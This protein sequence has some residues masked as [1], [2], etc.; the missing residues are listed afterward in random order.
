MKNNYEQGF[1]VLA[2][3][4]NNFLLQDKIP[5]LVAIAGGTCSGKT[6]LAGILSNYLPQGTAVVV[7]IDD[8]FKNFDDSSLPRNFRKIPN[9]D[10]PEAYRTQRLISTITDLKNGKVSF[11]PL[12][13]MKTNTLVLEEGIKLYPRQVIIA[14]GL[15]AINFL[16]GFDNQI[17]VFLD[18]NP[19]D[20]FTRRVSRDMAKYKV[21]YNQ[22]RN[23]FDEVIWPSHLNFVAGQKDLADIVIN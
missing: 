11:S 6:V 21:S 18:I 15:F 13:D 7:T 17:K 3:K 16:S 10:C 5:L 23:K 20:S 12:Y 19:H 22:V 8:Y 14:E 4:I 1:I 2:D 9:F